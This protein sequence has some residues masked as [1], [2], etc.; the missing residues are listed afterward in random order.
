MKYQIAKFILNIKTSLLSFSHIYEDEFDTKEGAETAVRYI[1]DNELN[2]KEG[3]EGCVPLYEITNLP[4]IMAEP[5]TESECYWYASAYLCEGA[6]TFIQEYSANHN[7]PI[8][9]I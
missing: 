3:L 4:T 9:L 6:V 2:C 7:I 8:D 5:M 1:I